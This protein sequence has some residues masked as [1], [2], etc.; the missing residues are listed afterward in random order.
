M[1]IADSYPVKYCTCNQGLEFNS[2]TV[3]GTMSTT[4]SLMALKVDEV[5]SHYFSAY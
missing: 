1:Y 2:G 5:D 3:L 4:G